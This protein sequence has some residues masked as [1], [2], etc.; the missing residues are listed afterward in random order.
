MKKYVSTNSDR[1]ERIKRGSLSSFSYLFAV[2]IT[3]TAVF[4]LHG[5]STGKN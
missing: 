4:S 2:L 3:A 5:C 1:T